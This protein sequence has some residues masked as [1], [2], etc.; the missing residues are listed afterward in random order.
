MDHGIRHPSTKERLA[1]MKLQ[2]QLELALFKAELDAGMFENKQIAINEM[3]QQG[4]LPTELR[5]QVI[6]VFR[7]WRF[8]T[9]DLQGVRTEIS[10]LDA[11]IG[12]P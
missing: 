1:A 6:G 8:Q 7:T 4:V 11:K 9:G 5:E 10:A 3:L 2:A 12:A